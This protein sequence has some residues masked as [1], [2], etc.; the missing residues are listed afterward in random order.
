MSEDLPQRCEFDR[1]KLALA[2]DLTISAEVGEIEPVVERIMDEVRKSSCA[3]GTEF[4]VETSLREALANAVVHGCD[5]DPSAQVRICVSCDPERGIL[6]VVRD[7]GCG[8]DPETVPSPL[9]AERLY[10][11]HGR[12]IYLINELMD[13]VH[14]KKGGTEIWMRK[15]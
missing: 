8:F 14:F 3:R 15:R 13:E 11:S 4:E 7:P 6:I 1:G 5:R 10:A 2:L 9:H 12:G